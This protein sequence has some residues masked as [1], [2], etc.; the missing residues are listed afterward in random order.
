MTHGTQTSQK[1]WSNEESG[2]MNSAPDDERSDASARVVVVGDWA[3]ESGV[4]G[5]AL[6]RAGL[7]VAMAS[8]ASVSAIEEKLKD[9]TISPP[10]AI[11][12]GNDAAI[13]AARLVAVLMGLS[14]KVPVFARGRPCPQTIAIA[15]PRSASDAI[16]IVDVIL[17][18]W[19]DQARDDDAV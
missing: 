10:D 5:L 9:R 12:L 14:M 6:M 4:I 8:L 2:A 15:D 13:D 7:N 11:I 18:N 1:R 17:E 3:E 19:M 16:H